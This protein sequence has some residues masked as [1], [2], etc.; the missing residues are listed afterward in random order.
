[1]VNVNP[2]TTAPVPSFEFELLFKSS[3]LHKGSE[4]GE[5]VGKFT[6]GSV[7]AGKLFALLQAV[8][9]VAIINTNKMRFML[10]PSLPLN[11]PDGWNIITTWI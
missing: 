6:A 8:M 4:L 3:D 5:I 9:I 11:K 1:L 2:I 10:N 7:G